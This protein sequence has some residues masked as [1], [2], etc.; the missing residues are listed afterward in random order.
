MYY[1]YILQSKKTK[2][3]Y[4]GRSQNLKQ[5]FADHNSGKVKSTKSGRP[6]KIIFYE[7]FFNKKD[8]IRDEKFF[9]S[10]YGREV[11]REKLKYSIQK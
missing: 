11:L 9:K 10:G 4:T 1:V 2:K 6:W 3:F 5:R 7:A 8:S